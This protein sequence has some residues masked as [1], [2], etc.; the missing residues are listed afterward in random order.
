MFYKIAFYMGI[1]IW[2]REA[3]VYATYEQEAIDTIIDRL[4]ANG[5]VAVEDYTDEF[6]E[7]YYEDE[8]VVN[9]NGDKALVHY[10]YLKIEPVNIKEPP[11]EEFIS[12]VRETPYVT[13][14]WEGF[15]DLPMN[16]ETE[17]METAFM[18]FPKGTH[19]EEIWHWFEETFGMAVSDLMY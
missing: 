18:S 14:L 15:G 4:A 11:T 7:N 13:E 1:G 17:E 9:D 8:Y 10:G 2:L 5:D 19:R 6:R 3:Y 12:C 16:P